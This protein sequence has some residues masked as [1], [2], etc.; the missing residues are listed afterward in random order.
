MTRFHRA[1]YLLLPAFVASCAG[2]SRAAVVYAV[3]AEDCVAWM[4]RYTKN[5]FQCPYSTKN[6]R[7]Y[8]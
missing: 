6:R 3:P 5:V 7:A 1:L 4:K 2:P 8:R